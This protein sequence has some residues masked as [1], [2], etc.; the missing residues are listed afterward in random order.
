VQSVQSTME[1]ERKL[2]VPS[3]FVL[4][5]L[6]GDPLEPRLFTSIYYDTADSSLARAGITLR[7]RT[8]RG[9]SVWQLKLPAADARL[10]IEEAGGP[11]EPPAE[12]ARLLAAHLRDGTLAE[13]AR[14]RTR[15]S[16][17]LVTR[18]GTTAEVTVDEVAVL[19]AQRVVSEFAE[20]EIELRSGEPRRLRRIAL[21][22]EDAG[23]TRSDGRPKLFRLLELP[24]SAEPD[25][26]FE[27]LRSRL[28]GQLDAILA[29]DPGTRLGQDAE[30]LH[31]M[32]VAV[33]RTRAL[34]RAGAALYTNDVTVVAA[35]L[36][37]LGEV[38]GAVRDP[39]VLLERLR[40]QTETLG[41]GDRATRAVLRAIER[42]RNRGRTAMTKALSSARYFALLDT[43]GAT[44]GSLAPASTE[45]TLAELAAAELKRLRKRVRAAGDEPSDEEL[46]AIRKQGK[47][48]RY[49]LELADARKL[50]NRAK[51]LQDVLG[52]HQ[53]SVVAEERLRALAGDEQPI[54]ALVVGRLIERERSRR[55]ETRATWRKAWRRLERAA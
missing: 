40:A 20:I 13:V 22:L 4:P 14:L 21:E 26:A 43:L 28:R 39:D 51:G 15:R 27:T 33:R 11:G 31:D 41:E 38:L 6:G 10:E 3:G 37:W 16:G 46:H 53:D 17:T 2:D 42:E 34:L 30:S 36:K 23:A 12:I 48:A 5:D 45:S 1:H 29:N 24:E 19:D 7:R 25:G 44:I 47:R 9:L 50:A 52:D 55:A 35:E 54:D 32:R 49:A 8:E 18:K